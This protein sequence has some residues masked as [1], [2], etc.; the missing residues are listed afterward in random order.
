MIKDEQQKRLEASPTKTLL[1]DEENSYVLK[2]W[3]EMRTNYRIATDNINY[4][5]QTKRYDETWQNEYVSGKDVKSIEQL[6]YE[7][8]S[9][10]LREKFC[11][12]QRKNG[13][14]PIN[15]EEQLED[16]LKRI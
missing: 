14:H 6:M 10:K 7:S 4:V 11:T 1:P 12:Q 15:P 13:Y 9:S 16:V 3:N 8:I 5:V 2:H